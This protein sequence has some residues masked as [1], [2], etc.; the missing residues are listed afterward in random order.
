LGLVWF[1]WFRA[2]KTKTELIGFFKILIGLICLFS[3]FGFFDYFFFSFIGLITFLIFLLI[4]INKW[5]FLYMKINL[6]RSCD[7]FV[8]LNGKN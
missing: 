1:F 8:N 3:R 6:W 7:F 4:P 2:Y 5:Y